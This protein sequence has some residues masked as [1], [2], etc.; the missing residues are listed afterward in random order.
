MIFFILLFI[1]ALLYNI[2]EN[3]KTPQLINKPISNI[4]RYIIIDFENPN[5]ESINLTEFEIHDLDGLIDIAYADIL[6]S[7]NIKIP[8]FQ[9][10]GKVQIINDTIPWIRIDF[11]KEIQI[12]MVK[13][14]NDIMTEASIHIL[15]NDNDNVFKSLKSNKHFKTHII[16]PPYDVWNDMNEFSKE[17]FTTTTYKPHSTININKNKF[18]D[19]GYTNLTR[20]FYNITSNDCSDYC[21]YIDSKNDG[22]YFSCYLSNTNTDSKIGEFNDTI[23]KNKKCF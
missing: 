10:F 1:I 2:T 5:N 21:R 9:H 15:N 12:K 18:Q 11:H 7:S 17:T 20:G 4:G 22:V 16:H 6:M 3:F 13:I 23:L 8:V 19:P 14:S